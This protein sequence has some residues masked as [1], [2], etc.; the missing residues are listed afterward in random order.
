MQGD[1]LVARARVV[2]LDT[3]RLLPDVEARGP[4]LGSVR[5]VRTA[6][7]AD[8]RLVARRSPPAGDRLPA[9]PQVFELYVKGLVAET[10][11]TA[12]AFLEQALKAAPQ[13]DR[14]RLAIWDLHSEVVGSP[15][16]ARRGQRDPPA[17]PLLARRPVPS[18]RCR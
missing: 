15:A 1:Q 12:L 4:L 13:F 6:R 14:A 18:R 17:E 2:R 5:R 11:S 7:A 8:S 9:T 16:G 10:P 3:G